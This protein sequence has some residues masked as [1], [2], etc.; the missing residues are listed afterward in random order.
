LGYHEDLLRRIANGEVRSKDDLASCKIRLAREYGLSRIPPNSETLAAAGAEQLPLVLD[1]LRRKPVRTLSGV[2]VVAAMTS[3]AQCPHGKCVFCP[4]GVETGSPQSYT[5]REPAALRGASHNFDAYDQVRNRIEQLE[6]IG[7]RAD[8]IDL[9]VMGGTF[10]SRPR[11]YQESFV[12]GCLDAMNRCRSESLEEAQLLNETAARRCIGLTIETRPDALGEE[13]VSSAL[14]LGATRA[15]MGVQILD[16]GI[17][18]SVGRGHG[19]DDIVRATRNLRSAGLKVC[20]HVMPGLPGSSPEKDMES[21]RMM[22]S[23]PR[24]RPDMVKIYPTL[25]V[26]GTEL[27]RMWSRGEYRPMATEEAAELLADMKAATPRWARIQRV[28]RDIPAPLIEAGPDKGHLRELA[29]ERLE[30]DGRRCECIRCREAGLRGVGTFRMDEAVANEASYEASG[31]TERFISFDLPGSDSLLGFVR[32]RADGSGVASVRELKV[33]GRMAPL[34]GPSEGWQHRGLGR[35][36]MSRAEDVAVDSGCGTI[37]VTS[38]VGVRRY[39]ASLGYER[40]GPYMVKR[41]RS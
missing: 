37:R 24:F 14:S 26:A 20:Y 2:A 8:K 7:H 12:K 17:L 27:H 10:T 40:S 28:Q 30:R 3:P 21:Y 4:G 16:D 25:V 34:A 18:R 1:V 33:F 6:A 9:I 41:L 19:L 31:G 11:E 35:E 39:Y 36:L 32:L 15:E 38:G 29:R 23:D 13:A 5:G 22:F